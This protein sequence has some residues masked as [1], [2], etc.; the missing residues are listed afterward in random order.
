MIQRKE[1]AALNKGCSSHFAHK[2]TTEN[3]QGPIMCTAAS[4]LPEGEES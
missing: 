3:G 2:S 4:L 1:T